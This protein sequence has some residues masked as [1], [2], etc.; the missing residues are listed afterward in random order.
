MT[1]TAPAVLKRVFLHN[2]EI[3]T[4]NF[5]NLTCDKEMEMDSKSS[6]VHDLA[7]F[8]WPNPE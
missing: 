7:M 8:I 6:F 2:E 1:T 5:L 3:L 4:Q